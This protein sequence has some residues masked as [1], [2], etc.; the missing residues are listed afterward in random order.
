MRA[1]VRYFLV[2]TIV[3]TAIPATA[4]KVGFL[5]AERA[6]A[7]VQE[8]KAKIAELDAWATPRR[9]QLAA[10]RQR[11]VELQEQ[12]T[13]QRG[14]ASADILNQLQQDLL[15]AQREFEDDGR[16]F[17]HELEAKQTEFLS[18]VAMKVGTVA[19][20]Y[21]RANDF[22]AIFILKAQPLVFVADSAD[23]TDIVIRLYDQRF[24]V[25]GSS[26]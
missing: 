22:D 6:V 13:R 12:L 7:S 18:E 19:S 26:N 4:G 15:Q 10:K 2:L 11:V 1:L 25:S 8:G 21:G 3:L 24:P 16:S 23:V 20:D 5:E 14:V 9:E 17:Q